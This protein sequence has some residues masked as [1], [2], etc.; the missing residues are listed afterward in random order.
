[1]SFKQ[2]VQ[3]EDSAET[4]ALV[5]VTSLDQDH[6]EFQTLGLIPPQSS[7]DVTAGNGA[8]SADSHAAALAKMK[9][10]FADMEENESDALPKQRRRIKGRESSRKVSISNTL[11]GINLNH[12]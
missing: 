11:C 8:W 1:M 9:R 4:S 6:D 2:K 3:G 12:L 10:P 7:R 5:V